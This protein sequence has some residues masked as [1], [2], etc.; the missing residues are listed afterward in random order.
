MSC[1]PLFLVVV[2]GEVELAYARASKAPNTLRGH[3][4]DWNEWSTWSTAHRVAPYRHT[5][6]TSPGT[7]RKLAGDGAKVGT[8]SRR[9]SSIKFVHE[10]ANLASPLD[11]AMLNAVWEG[12]RRTHGA[13][14]DQATPLMPVTGTPES[15]VQVGCHRRDASEPLCGVGAK[16]RA[17]IGGG[18]ALYEIDHHVMVTAHEPGHQLGGVFGVGLQERRLIDPERGDRPTRFGSSISGRPCRRTESM[19]V[20]HVTPNSFA[21]EA[22]ERAC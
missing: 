11:D 15:F 21:T 19:I 17:D 13:P 14:P 12:I 8:I 18:V 5:P 10:T 9:R 20:R 6:S 2:L 1:R 3:A 16:L 4:S 7:S 22:T